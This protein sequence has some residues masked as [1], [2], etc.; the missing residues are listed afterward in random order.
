MGSMGGTSGRQQTF[1]VVTEAQERFGD[2]HH[3]TGASKMKS[4][5]TCYGRDYQNDHWYERPH[6]RPR[7]TGLQD[8]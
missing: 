7:H 6:A 5:H 2:V 4:S 3:D 1:E 8:L